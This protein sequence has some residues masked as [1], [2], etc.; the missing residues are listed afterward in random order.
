MIIMNISGKEESDWDV[1]FH[2]GFFKDLDKLSN[3]DIGIFEKKRIKIIENPKRQKHLRGVSNCYREPI[4]KNIRVVYFLHQDTIW[5]LTIGPHDK[6]YDKFRER[7]H[8]IKI[9]YGLV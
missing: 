5:F 4:T 1:K 6:A 3:K 7:L 9:K 8:K 2:N